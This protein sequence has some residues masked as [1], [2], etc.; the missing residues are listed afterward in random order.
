MF[1][2]A[3]MKTDPYIVVDTSV[4]RIS[5]IVDYIINL[6]K[7]GRKVIILDCV[8]EEL[9]SL[10]EFPI[11]D[12]SKQNA[13]KF[14]T[15]IVENQKYFLKRSAGCVFRDND[16]NILKYCNKHK[17]DVILFTCDKNLALNCS[18]Q[19]IVYRY[20]DKD[21]DTSK[22]ENIK[23]YKKERI[24]NFYQAQIEN[25]KLKI[26]NHNDERHIAVIRDGHLF[27]TEDGFEL[28][29]DDQA[30]VAIK[31]RNTNIGKDYIAFAAYTVRSLSSINN[32]NIDYTHQFYDVYEIE[33][34]KNENFKNFLLD[35]A[36]EKMDISFLSKQVPKEVLI[37]N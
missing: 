26:F 35:Y 22:E 32:V 24:G 28:M 36:Q 1:F 6:T 9:D 30:M 13:R 7:N 11:E 17:E 4:M 34:L 31:K 10:K 3:K 18:R 23:A 12:L 20:F 16:N 14:L 33:K 25:G 8:Q 37:N 19:D 15:Y 21:L 5:G 29:L 2:K 27:E